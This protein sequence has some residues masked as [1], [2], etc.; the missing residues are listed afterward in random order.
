MR[1]NGD[2]TK[3]TDIARDMNDVLAQQ[4]STRRPGGDLHAD[5][6]FGEAEPLNEIRRPQRAT[7]LRS[8]FGNRAGGSATS[9]TH[10]L[11]DCQCKDSLHA[12]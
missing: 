5:W 12:D 7:P 10:A 8:H 11:R 3:L 2:A 1:A 4:S 6:R 9:R